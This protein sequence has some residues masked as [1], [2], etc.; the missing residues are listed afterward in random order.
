LYQNSIPYTLVYSIPVTHTQLIVSVL[1][2]NFQPSVK[3]LTNMSLVEPLYNITT[4]LQTCKTEE[5]DPTPEDTCYVCMRSYGQKDDNED[6]NEF[7]CDAVRLVPC[8]HLVGSKCLHLKI[9][10][11]GLSNCSFCTTPLTITVNPNQQGYVLAVVGFLRAAS[12]RSHTAHGTHFATSE[13]AELAAI[14]ATDLA[15]AELRRQ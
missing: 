6:P 12:C 13:D 2:C 8:G 7:P 4:S 5:A 14:T 1:N 3:R 9:R 10:R 15:I 11:Q